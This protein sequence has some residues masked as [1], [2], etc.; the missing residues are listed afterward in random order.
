MVKIAL[1]W[2][3]ERRSVEYPKERPERHV[4]PDL[5]D[6]PL[7]CH[8]LHFPFPGIDVADDLSHEVS[9]VRMSTR[10][11]GSRRTGSALVQPSLKAVA[12]AIL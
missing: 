6:G 11:I 1:P 10:M 9:G 3:A 8:G 7:G 12:V 5:G 2:V 4:R